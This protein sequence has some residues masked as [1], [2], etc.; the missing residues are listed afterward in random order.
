MVYFFQ[1]LSLK[2]RFLA[3]VLFLFPVLVFQWLY[4]SAPWGLARLKM[5]SNGVGVPDMGFW[6]S[7]S[8]LRD[9]YE[10]WGDAGR[11]HYWAVLVPTDV[12]FLVSYATLLTGG[13]LYWLKRTNPPGPWWYLLPLLPLAGA[14]FDLLENLSVSAAAFL[15]A[16]GWEPV[17]W[18]ASGFS[19]AKWSLLAATGAFLVVGT[20]VGLAL[21]LFRW[22]RVRLEP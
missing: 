2:V 3:L 16:S 18:M 1:T 6:Y 12:G 8:S 10:A 22:L 7:P 5:L 13:V 14:G 21:A 17:S 9:V 20:V 19:A 4:T 15:P 11:W